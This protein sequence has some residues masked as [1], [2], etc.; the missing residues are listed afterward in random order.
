MNATYRAD[1][2]GSTAYAV[3]RTNDV[4]LDRPLVVVRDREAAGDLATVMNWA[5]EDRGRHEREESC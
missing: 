1:A 2:W 5:A 3:Y 4:D